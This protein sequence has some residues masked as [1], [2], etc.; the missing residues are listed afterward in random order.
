MKT[1]VLLLGALVFCALLSGCTMR[2]EI[3]EFIDGGG[4]NYSNLELYEENGLERN[5]S[6]TPEEYFG[7]ESRDE[8]AHEVYDGM[9]YYGKPDNLASEEYDSLEAFNSQAGNIAAAEAEDGTVTLSVTAPTAL[10]LL[11]GSSEST[12]QQDLDTCVNIIDLKLPGDGWVMGTDFPAGHDVTLKF[13]GRE[14]NSFRL[15][16]PAGEENYDVSLTIALDGRG[17]PIE[18]A[19]LQIPAISGGMSIA[20]AN[21]QFEASGGDDGVDGDGMLITWFVKDGSVSG[22]AWAQMEE[23]GVLEEGTEYKVRV[24]IPAKPGFRF[25]EDAVVTVNGDEEGFS[26]DISAR[27]VTIEAGF[28]GDS[29]ELVEKVEI[30][31]RAVPGDAN[32]GE[33]I[34]TV[35]VL[36][37]VYPFASTS[38]YM[39]RDGKILSLNDELIPGQEY[40]IHITSLVKDGY[41]LDPEKTV[42]TVNGLPIDDWE[43][44]EKGSSGSDASLEAMIYFVY[45]LP[46]SG[47]VNLDGAVDARDLTALARHIANIETFTPSSQNMANADLTGD[48]NVSAPDLTKLAR[49]VA[50]IE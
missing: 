4:I 32:A 50:N 26:S 21:D 19:D 6:K 14:P 27:T 46:V 48:G 31:F 20:E 23:D 12:T 1:L 16:L 45:S 28:G 13:T 17:T 29:S 9:D 38:V 47:D 49:R 8:L 7:V 35:M 25:A 39:M 33:F 15:T 3:I 22:G 24:T 2:H 34:G 11:Q 42:V 41:Y 5:Q 36:S 18:N 10:Q 37:D 43:F 40:G 30:K 44:H